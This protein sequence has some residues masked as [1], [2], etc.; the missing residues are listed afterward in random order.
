MSPRFNRTESSHGDNGASGSRRNCVRTRVRFGLRLALTSCVL[1]ARREEE[2]QQIIATHG[3][4]RFKV[5]EAIERQFKTLQDRAQ[6]LLAVCGVLLTSSVLLVTGK[7]IARRNI[8]HLAAASRFMIAAGACDI[9]AG[10]IAV[11]AVLVVRWANPPGPQLQAWL[12]S[13][14][15]YRDR[16]THA[17][18]A[19]ILLVLLAM[20]LY[21][22]SATIVLAQL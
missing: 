13:R 17:L 2:S 3:G 22:T 7:I 19:S 1:R 11:G 21:Q 12:L 10:A 4:D 20:I 14:L 15:A 16:K 6:V 5:A 9:L 8:P 18:H